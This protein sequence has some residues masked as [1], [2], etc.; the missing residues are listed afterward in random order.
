MKKIIFGILLIGVLA[1]ISFG[2]EGY[3]KSFGIAGDAIYR[4]GITLDNGTYYNISS[5][6]NDTEDK[7]KVLVALIAT[8]ISTNSKVYVALNS[9]NEVIHIFLVNTQH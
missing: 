9:N 4:M 6:L 5:V 7:K 8:I 3:V 2:A 1:S